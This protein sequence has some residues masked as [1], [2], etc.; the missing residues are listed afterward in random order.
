[1][2]KIFFGFLYFFQI[3]IIYLILYHQCTI[4]FHLNF[5]NLFALA[6]KNN[7]PGNDAYL[8]GIPKTQPITYSTERDLCI[9]PLLGSREVFFDINLLSIR[10][11]GCAATII[12]LTNNSTVFSSNVQRLIILFNVKIIKG[13][14]NI[15]ILSR[16]T[17]FLRDTLCYYLLK[18]LKQEMDDS[19]TQKYDR[20]F[21]FDSFDVYFEKDPFKFFDKD[22]K[23]Y[24]FQESYIKLSRSCN[25]FNRRGVKQCFGSDGLESIKENYVVCSGTIAAGSLNSFLRFLDFFVH[26]S[27]FTKRKCPYDQGALIYIVYSG[28]LSKNNISFHVFPPEGPVAACRYGP[29]YTQFRTDDAGNVYMVVNSLINNHTFEVVHQYQKFRKEFYKK[30]LIGK[31]L[32][33]HPVKNLSFHVDRIITID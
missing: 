12:I 7:F 31:Y 23:I 19:K 3:I 26:L 25:W 28:L 16:H 8:Y 21:F 11:S 17:D 33:D 22:D 10:K 20:I 2:N 29:V 14:F 24:F 9:T 1:M 27:C 6:S 15:D 30:T 18:E 4:D 5:S 32:D 13:I